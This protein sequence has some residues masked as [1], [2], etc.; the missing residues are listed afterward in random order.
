MIFC[1]CGSGLS[2]IFILI[3]CCLKLS[4][5]PFLATA[6][7]APEIGAL[8]V[9]TYAYHKY[10]VF[11]FINDPI[12]GYVIICALGLFFLVNIS[13]FCYSICAIFFND[14]RFRRWKK[15]APCIQITFLTFVELITA[16]NFKF[17]HLIWSGLRGTPK[18][19]S[20][21]KLKY[22]TIF[23]AINLI[24]S[25]AFVAVFI[26]LINTVK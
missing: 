2:L 13:V 11:L 23:S 21:S 9:S 20:V 15:H 8:V 14:D 16:I 18:L 1:I 7:G 6:W 3:A 12:F 17:H 24:N 4:P 25:I 22:L 26:F 10:Y 5:W 19:E